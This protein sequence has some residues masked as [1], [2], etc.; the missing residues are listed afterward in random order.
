MR[1]LLVYKLHNQHIWFM[2][3][4]E[5][6]IPY[7]LHSIHSVANI[8]LVVIEVHASRQ[9][10]WCVMNILKYKQLIFIQM[11]YNIFLD[12]II[13]TVDS[14]VSFTNKWRKTRSLIGKYGQVFQ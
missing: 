5:T 1:F 3:L 11:I 7:Y 2:H 10:S 8:N 4:G 6:S 14:F 13:K 12:F 9:V